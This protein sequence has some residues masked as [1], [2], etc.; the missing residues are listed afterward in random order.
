MYHACNLCT[1]KILCLRHHCNIYYKG[2]TI[3]IKKRIT[4]VRMNLAFSFFIDYKY[5]LI[6]SLNKYFNFYLKVNYIQ[7]IFIEIILVT[8]SY[9][10]PLKIDMVKAEIVLSYFVFHNY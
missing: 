5:N 3:F 2:S 6:S 4:L 1:F 9:T 8:F 7:I 10:C